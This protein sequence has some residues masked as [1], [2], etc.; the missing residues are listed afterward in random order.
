MKMDSSNLLD[1]HTEQLRPLAL[2]TEFLRRA[3]EKFAK[4]FYRRNNSATRENEKFTENADTL[5]RR[6]KRRRLGSQSAEG[7]F[8]PTMRSNERW[9]LCTLRR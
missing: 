7:L 1:I 8:G 6:Q 3:D 4:D 9:S 2:H 5:N